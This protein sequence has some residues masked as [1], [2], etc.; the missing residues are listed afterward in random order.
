[1][2][3]QIM[4]RK[5]KDN[6]Y[7]HKD[8]HG[9]LSVGI[10]YLHQHYSAESV[11]E[12]LRQFASC[13]YAPLK[14][15]LNRRGL[16]ALREYIEKIYSIEGGTIHLSCSD[17]EL[18]LEVEA[19]PAIQHMRQNGHRVADLFYETTKTVNEA[20]CDGSPFSAE[21]IRYDNETGHSI[22]RFFR[23]KP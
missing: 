2:A 15:E 12:F 5:A 16:P 19:C 1:M 3:K 22:Q 8:F 13:F 11:R 9:A 18:E 23:R 4:K 6:V 14:A 7:L 20:I 21:L 17:D 10:D